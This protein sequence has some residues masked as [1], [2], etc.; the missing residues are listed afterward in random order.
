MPFQ[1]YIE[2]CD[3]QYIT[4]IARKH[5]YR[6]ALQNLLEAVM[7]DVTATNDPARIKCG[8][9]RHQPDT[10]ILAQSRLYILNICHFFEE[11]LALFISLFQTQQ[12]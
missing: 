3:K 8:N 2:A 7:P 4:G 6:P 12:T 10:G 5:A 11:T 1:K 9:P